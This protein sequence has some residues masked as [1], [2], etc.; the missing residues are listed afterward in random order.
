M[1]VIIIGAG[2]A[3]MTA[4][5]T[6]KK[7]DPQIDVT[8][9]GKEP[10]L[11]YNRYLLTEYLCDQLDDS[12]LYYLNLDEIKKL[13]IKFRKG[14][15]V[16]AVD[17][18]NK[19]IKLF[20]NE[21]LSFDKLLI[22]TGGRQHLGPLLSPFSQLIQSY[23]TLQDVQLLK[24]NLDN[25]EHCVIYGENLSNLDLL[26]G[27]YNLGKKITYITR[28]D[29]VLFPLLQSE[30]ADYI[31]DFIQNKGIEI[32]TN[33]KPVY[34]EKKD[35]KYRVLT[36]KNKKIDTD[37]IYAWDDRKPN[38]DFCQPDKVYQKKGILVDTHLQTSI[39]DIYAAGDCTEIYHPVLKNYWINFGWPNA[40][41]QGEIAGKNIAGN[42]I[43]YQIHETLSFKLM[44]KPLKARWWE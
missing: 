43:E 17:P 20:H 1:K 42:K 12:Q 7:T 27:M 24:R 15:S 18:E 6:I 39:K 40:Q 41:E 30:F 3:G 29:Q 33:D 22:A 16:K 10:Y 23:Y 34:V 11:P 44:G 8:V 14:E 32:I 5:S 4:A 9:I 25:I 38:I 26:A 2:I 21:V 31:H 37:I 13:G 28:R 19:K 36:L 35:N